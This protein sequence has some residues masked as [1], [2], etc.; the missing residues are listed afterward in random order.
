MIDMLLEKGF[1][2]NGV[3]KIISIWNE[4]IFVVGIKDGKPNDKGRSTWSGNANYEGS[5]K[6]GK[7]HGQGKG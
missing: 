2:C 5:Y 6:D 4:I 3:G 7:C 1:V